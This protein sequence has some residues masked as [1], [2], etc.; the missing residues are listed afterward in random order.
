MQVEFLQICVEGGLFYIQDEYIW[1]FGGVSF[2]F[3]F[4]LV[5]VEE[6]YG[7]SLVCDIVQDFVMYLCCLG[8]QLQFSCYNFQQIV[9]QGL[10]NDLLVWLFENFIVDFSVDKLVEKVVMSL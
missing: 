10:I 2:G 4:M 8:G 3:D 9:I 1:I 5:L 7:F 6:D